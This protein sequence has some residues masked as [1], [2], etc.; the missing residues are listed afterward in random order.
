LTLLESMLLLGA[1]LLAGMTN[2]IAGGGSL[3]TFPAFLAVGLPPLV[4]NV[5]NTVAVWPGY[6]SASVSYR[7][8]LRQTRLLTALGAAAV[9]GGAVGASVQ[10]TASEEVFDAVV[11]YLVLGASTLLALQGRISSWLKQRE[12]LSDGTARRLP[13][14][15][16]FLAAVYGAYFTGGMGIILLAALGVT[17]QQ[18]LAELN[19]LK[20]LLTLVISSVAFT[21]FALFGPVDWAGVA[22]VAPTTFLGGLAGARVA[23]RIEPQKLRVAVVLLGALVAGR[24]LLR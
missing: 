4:A 9:A 16:A 1:G 11:P 19:G 8:S 5:T 18:N 7:S 20:T 17:L 21:G 23:Q 12:L 10:L 6:L 22:L 24:L 15:A 3:I 14:L 13:S 2:A